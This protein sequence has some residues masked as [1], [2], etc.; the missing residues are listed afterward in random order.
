MK[1]NNGFFCL[2]T[3]FVGDV[4]KLEISEVDKSVT[5]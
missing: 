2:D 4:E 5:D 1:P 3:A